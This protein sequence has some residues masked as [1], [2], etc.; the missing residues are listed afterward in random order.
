[1]PLRVQ[2]APG[3]EFTGDLV[4]RLKAAIRVQASPRHVPDEVIVVPRVPH[5]RTGKRL[6]QRVDLAKAV[7]AGTVD[8]A[9]LV[10]HFVE[11][12]KGRMAPR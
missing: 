1:M 9:S 7:N 3:E 6:F 11:L 10:E 4:D 2:F 12:A 5:T 8:D